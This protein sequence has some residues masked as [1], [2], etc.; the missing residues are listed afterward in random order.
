VQ[1]ATLAAGAL[2]RLQAERPA[3]AI[4]L[5]HNLLRGVAQTAVQLTAEVAALEG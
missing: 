4:T 5:M 2:L 1:A 3:L